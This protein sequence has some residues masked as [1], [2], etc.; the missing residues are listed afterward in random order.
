MLV[1]PGS[2]SLPDIL[3]VCIPMLGGQD[4][5]EIMKTFGEQ[6]RTG[7]DGPV[8]HNVKNQRIGLSQSDSRILVLIIPG[9]FVQRQPFNAAIERLFVRQR[10][11]ITAPS[12]TT[13]LCSNSK[14]AMAK[15]RCS[16]SLSVSA[17]E[18]RRAEQCWNSGLA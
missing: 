5:E 16:G 8:P 2:L 13:S 10:L 18:G 1:K 17:A 14:V 9:C 7:A 11:D 4:S 12:P 6:P 15:D 3:S